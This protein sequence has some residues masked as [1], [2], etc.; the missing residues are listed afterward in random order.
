M[1]YFYI[2]YCKRYYLNKISD[3]LNLYL[4]YYLNFYFQ[5]LKYLVAKKYR[6]NICETD[7]DKTTG[8]FE[9]RQVSLPAYE[10]SHENPT[11]LFDQ[12][13]FPDRNTGCLCNKLVRI[14]KVSFILFFSITCIIFIKLHVF[15]YIVLFFSG[16]V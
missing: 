13:G 10:C 8:V 7:K 14:E 16:C 5:Y 2:Y 15:N 6:S 12:G 11:G 1:Q 3:L 4:Q 9:T